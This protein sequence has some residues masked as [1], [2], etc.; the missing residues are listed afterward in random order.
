MNKISFMKLWIFAAVLVFSC[1]LGQAQT[2][3]FTYQGKLNDTVMPMSPTYDFEFRLCVLDTF[4]CDVAPVLL[5]I[6]Q[7]LGVAVSMGI[8]P[9]NSILPHRIS[10][11]ART[12]F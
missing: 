7:R 1:G 6:K 9:S 4:N 8:L 10:P 2:N 12:D 3:E 11:A 5:E